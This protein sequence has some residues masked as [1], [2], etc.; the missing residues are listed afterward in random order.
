MK[1][2]LAFLASLAVLNGCASN[3]APIEDKPSGHEQQL[4]ELRAVVDGVDQQRRLLVLKGDD[5]QATV[6][7]V[8]LEFRDFDKLRVDD[9]VV[10]SYTQAVAWQVK[11]AEKGAPGVSSRQ[12]LSNP[13]PGESPGG[14]LERAMTITATISAFDIPQSTVT[15]T[16]PAGFSETLKVQNP[17]DLGRIRVGDLVDITYTEVRALTVRPDKR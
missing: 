15:L 10:V 12:T 3:G 17:A 16:G 2:L 6:L 14:A 11:P 7:P 4:V 9:P 5:G 8:A 1:Y 13:K